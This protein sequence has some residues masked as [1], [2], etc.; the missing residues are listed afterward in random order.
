M[1]DLKGP[2]MVI[3]TSCSSSLV[4]L[5][6]AC[7]GI[8]NRECDMAIA[9]GVKI[10]LLPLKMGN[11][12]GVESSDGRTRAFDDGSDGTGVGEGVFT[13]LLKPLAQAIKDRDNIYAVIKGSA[14]NQDGRSV[15]ITAPSPSAQEDVIIQA[16]KNSGVD[17]ETITYIEA[18]GT[19]TKLG[20]PIEFEGIQR[21]FSR[22]TNRKSFCAI[23]SVK[24]NIGHLDNLA[25][26]AGV[27]KMVLSLK[28]KELPPS[29]HYQKPNRK[30][31]FEDSPVYVNDRL[32]KWKPDGF[33]LRCGVSSFGLS[34]TN[35][36]V[37]LEEAPEININRV[38]QD[39]EPNI[40]TLSAKS[41]SSLQ[42]LIKQYAEF[43]KSNN[44]IEF[45]DICYTANTGRGHYPYRLAI[46]AMDMD[47]LKDKLQ[48]V[49]ESGDCQLAVN[50][51]YYGEIKNNRAEEIAA[52]DLEAQQ[53]ISY[54]EKHGLRNDVFLNKICSLY[55][56]GAHIHWNEIYKG[57]KLKRL[58][59]PTYP[60]DQT[61]CWVDLDKAVP[62]E[63]WREAKDDDMLYTIGW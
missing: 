53:T 27:L 2:S 30:I 26:L 12:I 47:D 14:L 18:H 24:T 58:S 21:A 56:K 48:K 25:G 45:D 41:K 23:G 63:P 7:Q 40:L 19:G 31:N 60:F 6:L 50:G 55:S 3:N 10:S 8:R 44:P 35:C 54:Y 49:N 51:V 32:Q 61:R 43:L 9:G 38:T 16:W 62:N 13:V 42:E 39:H 15:G 22:Y 37:I 46:H 17:P 52:A 36:H 59:L 1:L 11:G 5:H 28:H 20:D 29:L 34:G 33:L 4:A 57:E